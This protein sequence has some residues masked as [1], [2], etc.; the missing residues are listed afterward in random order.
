[1]SAFRTVGLGV[2]CRHHVQASPN[3][4]ARFPHVILLT[5]WSMHRGLAQIQHKQIQELFYLGSHCT[6]GPCT[7]VSVLRG[8]LF[9]AQIVRKPALVQVERS[10]PKNPHDFRTGGD[11]AQSPMPSAA[12]ASWVQ[13][14]SPAAKSEHKGCCNRIWFL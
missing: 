7:S 11:V 12:A 6:T 9:A 8:A 3:K 10:N 4:E 5:S 14:G 2:P 13:N 1:M